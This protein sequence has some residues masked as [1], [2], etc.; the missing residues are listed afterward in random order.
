M[1]P[2]AR[3]WCEEMAICVDTILITM[4][5]QTSMSAFEEWFEEAASPGPER[6]IPSSV[7][8]VVDQDGM[9]SRPFSSSTPKMPPL[10]YQSKP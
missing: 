9:S 1:T 4:A 6:E 7:V 3:R 5:S 10:L 2:S 8:I